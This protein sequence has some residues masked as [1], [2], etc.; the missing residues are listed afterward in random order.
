MVLSR[1]PGQRFNSLQRI[2]EALAITGELGLSE[3]DRLQLRNAAIS[4]LALPDFEVIEE[5]DRSVMEDIDFRPSHY[6][7][8]QKSGRISVRRL[9]D[10]RETAALPAM[11]RPVTLCLSPDGRH[12][13][14]CPTGTPRRNGLL[15][16]WRLDRPQPRC[17]HEG[18]SLDSVM[19]D[20][21]PDGAR[22]VYE[23][24][25]SL[26]V[27]DVATGQARSWPLSGT[28]QDGGVRCRPGGR[29]VAVARTIN[30]K[31]VLEV[32]DLAS[33]AVRAELWNEGLC[34]GLDWH[35]QGRFLA[36]ACGAVISLWGL[37]A[38]RQ[39]SPSHTNKAPSLFASIAPA[40][41][42][43]VRTGGV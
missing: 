31:G 21:T 24:M 14:V 3:E 38:P 22:L 34:T 18:T 5:G 27:V 36:A 17:L 26:T 4:A 8:V 23:S 40:T 39:S 15:Q 33:G 28:P 30:G 29:E 9:R 41:A 13:A 12:V 37:E 2:R 11:D 35:P 7:V 10:D 19:V 1:L 16:L 25:N 20:F 6:V 42:C 32:R 43:S